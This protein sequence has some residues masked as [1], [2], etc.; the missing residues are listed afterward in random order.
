MRGVMGWLRGRGAPSCKSLWGIPAAV[1]FALPLLF[2]FATTAAEAQ[3][4]TVV[5]NLDNTFTAD[6][7]NGRHAQSFITGANS[8]GYLLSSVRIYLDAFALVSGTTPVVV[9]RADSNGRPGDVVVTLT[10]PDSFPSNNPGRATFTAPADTTLAANTTYWMVINDTEGSLN[11]RHTTDGSETGLSGW[12]M[13]AAKRRSNRRWE[14]SS[15]LLPM[16]LSG[17]NTGPA[18][19][20]SKTAAWDASAPTLTISGVPARISGTANITA[21]F[22]FSEAVTDFVTGDVTVTGGT[23]GTFSGSGA[24]Y[25]LV[26]APDGGADVVVTVAASTVSYCTCC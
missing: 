21:T 14:N 4:V 18:S 11:W 3:T 16:E 6:G 1:L 12:S 26:I 22:T 20:E 13:G 23:A 2:G 7:L 10:N 17:T 15:Q 24:T 5:S 19:A 9:I 8:R 25:T